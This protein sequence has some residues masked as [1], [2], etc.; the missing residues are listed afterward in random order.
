MAVL[1]K[2]DPPLLE[3]LQEAVLNAPVI[4]EQAESQPSQLPSTVA[5]IT[6]LSPLQL[7]VAELI[8]I[9]EALHVV[10]LH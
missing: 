1:G 6:Q 4:V 9:F 7:A 3:Q 10:A 5:L 2:Q 8:P